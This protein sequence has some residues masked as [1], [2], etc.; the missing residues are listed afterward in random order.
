MTDA[1]HMVR[2]MLLGDFI[3]FFLRYGILAFVYTW[4]GYH[5][6]KKGQADFVS[7]M[8]K[9]NWGNLLKFFVNASL[10]FL[11]FSRTFAS[12]PPCFEISSNSISCSYL[13]SANTNTPQRTTSLL[14]YR[15][16]SFHKRILLME[17]FPEEL[18]PD[19][20]CV[21]LNRTKQTFTPIIPWGHDKWLMRD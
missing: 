13:Q 10:M 19:H 6:R 4:L 8:I 3:L 12:I 15:L 18:Q 1:F 2:S 9:G 21:E 7:L 17:L 20:H 5:E 16:D 14:S 11:L